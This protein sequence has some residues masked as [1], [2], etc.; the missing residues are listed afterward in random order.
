ML[1]SPRRGGGG[2]VVRRV[3]IRAG[4]GAGSDGSACDRYGSLLQIIYTQGC[5]RMPLFPT[6]LPFFSHVRFSNC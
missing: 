1:A 4:A 2:G 6:S 5:V 3:E